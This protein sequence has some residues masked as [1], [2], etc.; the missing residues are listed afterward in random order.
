[1]TKAKAVQKP[2]I[3][4]I[5]GLTPLQQGMLYHALYAPDS[6]QYIQQ[7]RC[8]LQAGFDADKLREAVN[9][10]A[11]RHAVLRTAFVWENR[12][13]PIQV[14]Q[15]RV[16]VPWHAHDWR[17]LD[18]ETFRLRVH[19]ATARDSQNGFELRKAPLMRITLF[20]GPS[21][22]LMLWST[23]HILMDGGCQGVLVGELL[24][25]YQGLISGGPV[26]LPTPRPFRDY[27]QWLQRQDNERAKA[28]WHDWLGDFRTPVLPPGWRPDKSELA[29]GDGHL[30]EQISIATSEELRALAKA[31]GFTVNVFFQ[32]LLGLALARFNNRQDAVFGA[33]TS[34]R[35][36]D[37]PGSDA[38]IGLFINT[39]PVRVRVEPSTSTV[40]WLSAF[41]QRLAEMKSYEYASL[42]D[43]HQ[44][45]AVPRGTELF[46]VIYS[47]SATT[48]KEAGSTQAGG[49]F[50]Q[51]DEA[52]TLERTN[53]P[54]T[55]QIK[56]GEQAF[57][58]TLDYDKRIIDGDVI[59]RFFRWYMD[60]VDAMVQQAD[61]PLRE[62]LS[63]LS[64]ADKAI[65][66]AVN[67]VSQALPTRLVFHDIVADWVDR[68][69]AAPAVI[70]VAE[71][72]SY[73]EL[74]RRS[75]RF[76]AALQSK[77]L[78][79]GDVVAFC[80]GRG[81]AMPVVFLGCL[82]AGCVYV[83][84]D[85]TYPLE[86]LAFML[87][88]SGAALLVYDVD[89]LSVD[90]LGHGNTLAL[91]H[92]GELVNDEDAEFTQVK[93]FPEDIAYMIYTSGSTGVPKGV[94][95]MHAGY[96]S[97]VEEQ[98]H[99]LSVGPG[100]RT[101]QFSSLSFD[102]STWELAKSIGQ[103]AALVIGDA[104]SL[105]PGP[106]LY[107][108]MRAMKVSH[109]VLPPSALANI[110]HQPLPDL[111]VLLVAG[112]A[113]PPGVAAYWSKGRRFFNAYGPTETTIAA[114]VAPE[115]NTDRPNLTM[116]RPLACSAIHLVDAALRRVPVGVPGELVVSG[117]NVARGYHGRPALTASK[118]VA[119]P[120]GDRPGARLYRT[121]D[122]VRCDGNGEIVYLGRIDHQVKI[123]GYR[124]E[125]G[126]IEAALSRHPAVRDVAV[127]VSTGTVDGRQLAAYL[128][129]EP[130]VDDPGSAGWKA[131]LEESL[132][133]YMVPAYFVTLD[134]LPQTPGN[135]LDR[136]ALPDPRDQEPTAPYVAPRNRREEIIAGLWEEVFKKDRVSVLDNFFELGGH[137][138]LAVRLIT[139]VTDTFPVKVPL[140][141]FLENPTVE[142]F[143][144]LVGQRVAKMIDHED[145][146]LDLQ[147]ETRLDMAD[148]ADLDPA[149]VIGPP[150]A[151]FLTGATGFLGA[152]LL[153]E[154]LE[155][156]NGPVYCLVRAAND[157]KAASRLQQ[158]LKRWGLSMSPRVRAMA[159]DLSK[160]RLGLGGKAFKQLAAKIDCIIHN[161][162]M[163]NFLF[164]Y[165]VLKAPNV[166]GTRWVLRLAVEDH[167]KPVHYMST[168]SVFAPSDYC[169]RDPITEDDPLEAHAGLE[170]GYSQTKWV[171]ERLLMRAR[172]AGVPV[173]SYR[174][175]QVSGHSCHGTC[176]PS[177]LTWRMVRSVVETGMAPHNMQRTLDF[178]PVD[179]VVKALVH[180]ILSPDPSRYAFHI[181]NAESGA[182]FEDLLTWLSDA[183]FPIQRVDRETWR[184]HLFA[185]AANEGTSALTPLLP[186]L[187]GNQ[188][189][190]SAVKR[191]LKR[192]K[193]SAPMRPFDD[194]WFRDA[195]AATDIQCPTVDRDLVMRSIDYLVRSG[196]LSQP[197]QPAHDDS[198]RGTL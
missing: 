180:L 19:N 100:N 77:G 14:V 89:G 126:E 39:L 131:F 188:V 25:L 84:L 48:T 165:S 61:E 114:S 179:Y 178:M 38:M 87:N 118:F 51:L 56:S 43:V 74:W 128:V 176:N 27:I 124:I 191:L 170:N 146:A 24:A 137:S 171:A 153:Q 3:E 97:L 115:P 49:G 177:D 144:K 187:F 76:A 189:P 10:L 101:L 69:G 67:Q 132:V 122:L 9:M 83:P 136:D 196:E 62:V 162:A 149:S 36:A 167:L 107:E 111:K 152:F 96:C 65:Y 123:R 94:Q 193:P 54:L 194:T 182:Y 57:F 23:H 192:L 5:Y 28:F 120:F 59:E 197:K 98:R 75:E 104:Q 73:E 99:L 103:G 168:L 20:Y 41:G 166:E 17:D 174:L 163:V 184:E 183:G 37:L 90:G 12:S 15:R 145:D 130:G 46:Q 164:P 141:L 150:R 125:L 85:V 64:D 169:G 72:L 172:D 50:F 60:A 181:R 33:V 135:K 13:E 2:N 155:R 186:A 92:N 143:A 106:D 63:L 29:T 175:G 195:L 142:G 80:M 151:V 52:V 82:R 133:S 108:F 32:A 1:M 156:T 159:G 105:L 71:T 68:D 79:R 42:I 161:G 116:G 81:A 127:I 113:C 109:A 119:D 129:L 93:V 110:P 7:F 198:K 66:A 134:R 53:Y 86:R 22:T 55:L 158:N 16:Q 91:R 95:V 35:P 11:A 148:L 88:D 70:T 30:H 117:I 160:K 138:L 34:G 31:H 139:K 157:G 47:Y 190:Q 154:L 45:T 185:D 147:A 4:A 18:E 44:Q 140:K 8:G 26:E 40:Q 58:V 112:E 121:G 102:A 21:R 6:G 173:W 78:G